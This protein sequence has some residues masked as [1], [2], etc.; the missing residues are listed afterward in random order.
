VSEDVISPEAY[1]RAMAFAPPLFAARLS[2][3][4]GDGY[5]IDERHYF[6]CVGEAGPDGEIADRPW[7]ADALSGTVAPVLTI[8]AIAMLVAVSGEGLA[9]ARYDMPDAGTLV[10]MIGDQAHHLALD[11]PALIRVETLD[12]APALHS[13]DG[14]FAAYLKDNNVWVRDR[15]TGACRQLAPD[16]EKHYAYGAIPESAIMPLSALRQA[17][18]QGLWSPDSEWLVVQRIDERH[19][20]ESGLVEHVP[21]AGGRAIPHVFKVSPPGSELATIEYVACHVASGRVV[22]STDYPM[23]ACSPRGPFTLRECWFAGEALYF[24][25]WGRFTS[26]VTLVEMPL[27]GSAIRIIFRETT[28]SGWLNIHPINGEQPLARVLP[29]SRELIWYSDAQGFGHLSLH[30][31]ATGALKNPITSGEWAVRELVHV[32]ETRRRLLF[33][34][35]GFAGDPGRRHLCTIGLDGH[36][37]ERLSIDGDVSVRPDPVSGVLQLKPFRPCY[38]PTGTAMDGRHL[39]AAV[40]DV[41]RGTRLLLIDIETAVQVELARTNIDVLWTAPTPRRFEVLAADGVTP[42]AGAMHLPTGFDPARSYPLIVYIYPGPQIGP[43]VRRLPSFT[44]LF[45]QSV[46]ELGAVGI[47]LETRGLPGRSR[48]FHQAGGGLTHEPQLGDHVSAIAQLCERHRFIDPERIGIFGSSAGGY[49][50]AR[51]L[52]DYPQ[53]F[54][55]GVA[56]AGMHDMRNFVSFWADRYGGRPGSPA[57][58]EQSNIAVAHRL[59]GKLC[60]IH[61]DIDDN[62]LVSHTLAVVDALIKAD[63]GFELLIVPG[64]G[65]GVLVESAYAYRRMLDFFARH[66]IEAEPPVAMARWTL[67]DLA[68]AS[69]ALAWGA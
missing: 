9:G 50:T 24:F 18:P 68:K 19:L 12:P 55:V 60:L 64:A 21:A 26:E 30:D 44:G 56:I 31:L 13:P 62:C 51:A 17:V 15:A 47:V 4:V 53:I 8:E 14:R 49:A 20:G 45:L 23:L 69:R 1:A 27:D 5:W 43:F 67:A 25:A 3:G 65:H 2:G 10:V 46:T 22:S 48:A 40:G 59:E 41:D 11:G 63:K 57:R 61:G 36:G 38:A 35:S 16:G 52:F 29:A 42:L 34:A 33:L 28:D 58:D 32:D 54:K 66:L 6:H 37:F 39:V 7:L